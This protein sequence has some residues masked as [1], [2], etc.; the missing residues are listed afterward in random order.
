MNVINR[1]NLPV[2]VLIQNC[3]VIG[4][5]GKMGSGIALLLL[6]EIAYGEAQAHGTVGKSHARLVLIDSNRRGLEDLKTY[7]RKQLQVYA[8][9]NIIP[10]RQHLAAL[11]LVSN[12][13]LIDYFIAGAMGIL[14]CSTS[15]AEAKDVSLCFEAIVE[16]IEAK[17]SLFSTLE[18]LCE[19]PPLYLTN[20]S[21]IPISLLNEKSGLNGRIIGFHF[22]N[23]PAVQKLLELIPLENQDSAFVTLASTLAE[24]FKKKIIFSR[25]VA[26][27]I[28]NGYLLRYIVAA[29]HEIKALAHK[30]PLDAAVRIVEHASSEFLLRPMGVFELIEYVGFDLILKI[31]SIMNQF[32]STPLYKKDL[33]DFLRECRLIL[34]RDHR[35]GSTVSLPHVTLPAGY[36]PWKILSKD[37]NKKEKIVQYLHQLQQENSAEALVAKK[38]LQATQKIA[39]GL[40][41]DGVAAS[42]ADVDAVLENGFYYLY[43]TQV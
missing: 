38:L 30:M 1:M 2:E 19:N 6:Q 31:G 17:V 3:A 27:F 12:R 41:A 13:E 14:Y 5:A 20:T 34:Y 16:D 28:G 21:T 33:E 23:P 18:A 32:L 42:I 26:G 9:K 22:Y 10:L 36:I 37:K 29:C 4:A 7:L 39:K 11:P 8:E 25:D 35:E 40:V 24:H 43:G 15:I